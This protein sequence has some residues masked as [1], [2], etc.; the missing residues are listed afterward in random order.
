MTIGQ[1]KKLLYWSIRENVN[2]YSALV[3]PSGTCGVPKSSG[4][5]AGAIYIGEDSEGILLEV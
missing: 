2:K 3:W 4:A 1:S 5:P